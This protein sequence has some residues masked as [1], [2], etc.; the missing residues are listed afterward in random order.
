MTNSGF[1]VYRNALKRLTVEMA[2]A[3]DE[4]LAMR[5]EREARAQLALAADGSLRVLWDLSAVESYS[6]E[7]RVVIVRLQRF[8]STKGDRTAYVAV[9]ATPRSLALWT[10]RMGNDDARACIAADHESAEA[11]LAGGSEPNTLIRPIVSVRP[12]APDKNS[13]TG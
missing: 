10:A 9:A 1:R 2:G 12:P 3:I 4:D 8:L 6:F 11:W 5:C 13:A 7:A